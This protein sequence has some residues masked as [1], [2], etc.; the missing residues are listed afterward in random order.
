MN[1]T[2]Y[3]Y[4]LKVAESGRIGKMEDNLKSRGMRITWAW[5]RCFCSLR[6]ATW[7]W[8]LLL[9]LLLSL[10]LWR[11]CAQRGCDTFAFPSRHPPLQITYGTIHQVWSI[12]LSQVAKVLAPRISAC[13]WCCLEEN[14]T[15]H[16][17]TWKYESQRTHYARNCIATDCLNFKIEW[18]C[19]QNLIDLGWRKELFL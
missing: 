8:R 12:P 1:K 11:R 9:L 19:T 6:L 16:S 15:E 2:S 14:L 17:V 18:I 13:R 3:N 5:F 4:S 7:W 10:L